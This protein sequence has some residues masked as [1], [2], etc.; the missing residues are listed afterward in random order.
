[1]SY[2]G[3]FSISF[4]KIMFYT[5]ILTRKVE[6]WIFSLVSLVKKHNKTTF[7]YRNSNSYFLHGVEKLELNHSYSLTSVMLQKKWIRK[8]SDRQ[9]ID[10]FLIGYMPK[11][12]S[13]KQTNI[14]MQWKESVII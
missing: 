12:E 13:Q 8:C 14:P 6:L 3:Y 10:W 4:E 9:L 5:E 2:L 7:Q 11:S 1:M